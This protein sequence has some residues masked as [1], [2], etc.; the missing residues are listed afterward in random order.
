MLLANSAKDLSYNELNESIYCIAKSN[1]EFSELWLLNKSELYKRC[2]RWLNRCEDQVDEA[3]SLIA[4]KAFLNFLSERKINNFSAWL[5]RLAYNVCIDVH[6]DTKR[7]RELVKQVQDLPNTFFFS[8]NQSETQDDIYSDMEF[9]D[10]IMLGMS[11]LPDTQRLAIKYR[12][13]YGMEYQEIAERL[14]ISTANVRK[15]VQLAR[16]Q[17]RKYVLDS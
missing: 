17:L 1:C 9:V 2:C 3:M 15:K 5:Y 14:N 8:S 13:L 12:T 11:K 6:R 7:Q 16:S 10:N 4:E